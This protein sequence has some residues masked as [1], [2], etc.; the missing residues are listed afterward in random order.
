MELALISKRNSV[1]K[2]GN[3]FHVKLKMDEK[4]IIN[5]QSLVSSDGFKKAWVLSKCKP[6]HHAS[7]LS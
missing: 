7:N 3:I 6:T 5:V 4:L 1:L 2:R